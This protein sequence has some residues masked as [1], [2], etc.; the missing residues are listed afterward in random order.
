MHDPG[1][2]RAFLEQATTTGS[3]TTVLK[4]LAWMMAICISATLSAVYFSSKEWVVILFAVFAGLTM[5][6]YL[7]AYLYCLINDRDALRSES[8]KIQKMA[9]EKG[10]VGDSSMGV[11]S[12]DNN[13]SDLIIG[14]SSSSSGE[15]K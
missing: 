12:L 15:L 10:F 8:Y 2:I 9:I 3:K 4:P 11:I 13:E 5:T 7:I 1:L 14:E 6:M